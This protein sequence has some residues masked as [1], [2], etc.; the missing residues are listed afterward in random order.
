MTQIPIKRVKEGV[1]TIAVTGS[2][3]FIP[4]D[5]ESL[6]KGITGLLE[7][8]SEEKEN[9]YIQTPY[10]SIPFKLLNPTFNPDLGEQEEK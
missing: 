8:F 3:A 10:G 1:I 6:E 9:I 7:F 4:R 2:Q 5:R